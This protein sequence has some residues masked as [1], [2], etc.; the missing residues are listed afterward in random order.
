MALSIQ[1]R[2]K[3]DG[4]VQQATQNGEKPDTI[5]TIVN[6][7]KSKYDA[8][9]SA[10]LSPSAQKD[11]QSA[12]DSGASFPAVAGKEGYMS[13]V[14]KMIGNVPSSAI[15][16]AKGF[17]T[18][19]TDVGKIPA[20]VQQAGGLLKDSNGNVMDA[21]KY[22]AQGTGQTLQDVGKGILHKYGSIDDFQRELINDPVGVL[23]LLVPAGLATKGTK[24]G[25][26]A[27]AGLNAVKTPVANVAR[28]VTGA[29][30]DLGQSAIDPIAGVA[31]DAMG[32][33]GAGINRTAQVLKGTKIGQKIGD[34]VSPIDEGTKTILNPLR[35]APEI[36]PVTGATVD[37]PTEVRAAQVA[38]K[39]AKLDFY[40]KQAKKAVLD[41]HK[42]TPLKIAG[43][44]AAEVMDTIS[45]KLSKQGELKNAA[46]NVV[47]DKPVDITDFQT[48][49]HSMITDR[50]GLSFDKEG[51]LVDAPGRMQTVGDQGDLSILKQI[52]TR[53]TK[54]GA[55]PTAKQVDDTVDYIQSFLEY[56]KKSEYQVSNSVVE[57]VLKQSARDLNSYVRKIAGSAYRKAN[58]KYAYMVQV[59]QDLSK[60]LGK[61]ASK[62]GSLMKRVFSPTDGGTKT[63]FADIKKITGVDLIE[64]ATFA[65][66]AMEAAGDYQQANLLEQLDLLRKPSVNSFVGK[67][68]ERLLNNMGDPVGQA[69]RVIQ[70]GNKAVDS[71]AIQ[72]NKLNPPN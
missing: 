17:A 53:I 21:L 29:A 28:K 1:D 40:L 24:V 59:K 65:K 69:K 50:L 47:A 48:K 30:V 27:D 42:D 45:T 33:V 6:D 63:L 51:N 72:R 31:G 41:P 64:E 70:E 66:F 14:G 62:G 19:I 7:F 5:Q 56:N 16:L 67:Q 15:N 18:A 71:A 54:L 25:T 11:Q 35:N 8:P 23:G 55:S 2:Q 60:A 68:I 22:F 43:G 52:N 12:Q 34:A 4:I 61:D 32:A 9:A 3:L 10:P 49:L 36:N 39:S 26:L 46:L 38:G 44:K 13:S 58:D 20:V 57:G 37:I